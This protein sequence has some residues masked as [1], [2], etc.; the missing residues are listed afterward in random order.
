MT[1]LTISG[2]ALPNGSFTNVSVKAE[3]DQV[4][5]HRD[6]E[7]KFRLQLLGNRMNKKLEHYSSETRTNVLD[8]SEFKDFVSAS[9]EAVRMAAIHMSLSIED[10]FKEHKAIASGH[11]FGLVSNIR[12]NIVESVKDFLKASA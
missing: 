3:C 12:N 4:G 7:I 6:F 1:H 10:R 5:S 11:S 2:N 8:S 9:C